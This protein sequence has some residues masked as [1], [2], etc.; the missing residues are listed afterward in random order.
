MRAEGEVDA[1]HERRVAL[2]AAGRSDLLYRLEWPADPALA[3][4]DQAPLAH[5]FDHLGREERRQGPPTRRGPRARRPPAPR[6]D[7]LAGRPPPSPR[8][9]PAAPREQE[10][11]TTGRQP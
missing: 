11:A 2:P 4:P 3:H 5:G 10:R 7:P 1:L 8:G 9:L 6:P